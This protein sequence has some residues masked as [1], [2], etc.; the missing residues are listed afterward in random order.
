MIE[1][2]CLVRLGCLQKRHVLRARSFALVSAMSSVYQFKSIPYELQELLIKKL[3]AIHRPIY[4]HAFSN[5]ER[6]D[7]KDGN[8]GNISR[9]I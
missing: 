8:A 6:N 3:F 5:W 2:R 7:I 1:Q 9:H 4:N